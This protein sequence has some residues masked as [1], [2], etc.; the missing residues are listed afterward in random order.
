MPCLPR[1]SQ[2]PPCTSNHLAHSGYLHHSPKADT[3]S[4][5]FTDL[6]VLLEKTAGLVPILQQELAW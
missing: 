3:S 6:R 5:V 1:N 4:P 2:K